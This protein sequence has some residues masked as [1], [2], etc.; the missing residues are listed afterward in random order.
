M[1]IE[2]DVADMIEACSRLSL[3]QENGIDDVRLHG[4]IAFRDGQDTGAARVQTRGGYGGGDVDVA[5]NLL[6]AIAG[7][8]E[9]ENILE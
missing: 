9:G 2:K 3:F 4:C 8:I 1:S 7:R 6:S 5:T